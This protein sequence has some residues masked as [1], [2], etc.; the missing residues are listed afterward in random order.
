[1]NRSP[2]ARRGAACRH[3]AGWRNEGAETSILTRTIQILSLVSMTFACRGASQILALS[4]A[5]PE[6]LFFLT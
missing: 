5:V 3:R 4:T 6:N 1:M 2:R